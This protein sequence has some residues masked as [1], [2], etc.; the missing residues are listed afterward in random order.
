MFKNAFLLTCLILFCLNTSGQ[1]KNFK[2]QLD[3]IQELKVLSK[4][5]KLKI[6]TRI[7]YAEKASELSSRTEIDSIILNSNWNLATVY[8]EH[9][10][11]IE[12]S[13]ILNH[14]NLRL[15]MKLNDSTNLAYINSHLG[16]AYQTFEA[17]NDS[18][19]YYY[20][21]ALRIF[22]KCKSL[23]RNRD[24]LYQSD[25]YGNIADILR[26]EHDYLGSQSAIIKAVNLIL[27]IPETVG[28][29][30]SLSLLYNSL[31]L[32]LVKLKEYD[33]ALNYYEKALSINDKILIDYFVN[34][35]SIEINI[36]EL[37]RK[38]GNYGVALKI[39]NKLLK[40]HA[41]KDK[42][43][44]SY[45]SILNN[46][47]YTMFLAK[48]KN[49]YKIDSLFTK[50]HKIFENLD[51]QYEI[52]AG[53][54]DMAEFYYE[55]NQKN[56]VLYYTK[57]SY[58]AGK[59]IKE[60]KEVLRS[61]KMFSKL[62][63]GDSGKAYL[64]EYIRLSDSLIAKE[65]VNRNKFARIQF[66]TDQYIKETKRL[67]TQN[68][69]ISAIGG[70]LLLVLGLLYFI[71]VQRSKNKALVFVSEQEKAN[72]EIYKL[73]LQQQTKEEE[74]RLQERNRIAEDLHDGVLS[75][76]FGT[77]MGLGFLDI[78]GEKD[79]LEKYKLFIEEMQGIEKEV[80]DV[81]HALKKDLE[82]SKANFESII[83][84]YLE[85]QS[86]IG[87]FKYKIRKETEVNLELLS[88]SIRV[89]IY[90]IIQ[91]AIQNIIKH[92]QAKCVTVY[93]SLLE[94]SVLEITIKDD[95]IGFD[96][97]RS[98]KGI[99]L[100]NITSRISKLAGD[101]KI[102]STSDKGTEININIPI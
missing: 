36:A 94:N 102:T 87:S 42:S 44:V 80:R 49:A 29:L 68:I 6:E 14:K 81:S 84:Q 38:R 21:N 11:Y 75:R 58:R 40:N 69:L 66:E 85:S 5:R 47:A 31:G 28:S 46:L 35:L 41:I 55:T 62:K 65:R 60:F 89:E 18:T 22:E 32:D 9:E 12:Q 7:Q 8:I 54:N 93:F 76:L 77:R 37:Y 57:Q 50:A 3:S 101:Y 59:N 71:R 70:I 83:E 48:D 67:S 24:K 56:K 16:Y 99:G 10:K 73:M 98:Y 4:N 92:S 45:G 78:K 96:A 2:K 64:S 17:M 51:L 52:S 39:Y 27:S 15:A 26:S 25:I 19:F 100:K 23:N 82:T 91:E 90:R 63:E 43:P 30:Q 53:G 79:T 34:K 88:E 61:L 97:T 20:S 1:K 13:I 86:L 74:G 33:K 95:G 72:Q